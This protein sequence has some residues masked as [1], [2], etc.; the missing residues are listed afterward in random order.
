MPSDRPS[1]AST[2]RLP[3]KPCFRT[4]VAPT[5]ATVTCAI[6]TPISDAFGAAYTNTVARASTSPTPRP[7]FEPRRAHYNTIDSGTSPR[8][9]PAPSPA[10]SPSP[11][12]CRRRPRPLEHG[13]AGAAHDA[14][15]VGRAGSPDG[16]ARAAAAFEPS[17]APTRSPRDGRPRAGAVPT[18]DP[19]AFRTRAP[20]G[21][22]RG[23]RPRPTPHPTPAAGDPTAA[24]AAPPRPPTCRKCTRRARDRRKAV[25]RSEPRAVRGRAPRRRRRRRRGAQRR[26]RRRGPATPRPRLP[27]PTLRRRC[28][29][30]P[31]AELLLCRPL[32]SPRPSPRPS[33]PRSP[34]QSR[35]AHRRPRPRPRR[36][37]GPRR[38]LR[39]SRRA[40]DG[41]SA[42]S[43]GDP[44]RRRPRRRRPSRRR[45]PLLSRRLGRRLRACGRAHGRADDRAAH[46]G[47]TTPR[48]SRRPTARRHA[49]ADHR[50]PTAPPTTPRPTI[51]QRRTTGTARRRP[52][53]NGARTPRITTT[54]PR[55]PRRRGPAPARRPP[56]GRRCSAAAAV[57][58][59]VVQKRDDAKRRWS[60]RPRL[61]AEPWY[62][63]AAVDFA[64]T[65]GRWFGMESAAPGAGAAKVEAR[66][67][68]RRCC[69]P[70]IC[71][72]WRWPP[73]RR[74]LPLVPS[75]ALWPQKSVLC[76]FSVRQAGRPISQCLASP[77]QVSQQSGQA[78]LHAPV[79]R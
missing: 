71:C 36:R 62:A 3:S 27:L 76:Y 77:R 23:P 48:P 4:T 58:A 38:G 73:V 20:P 40:V 79:A 46:A 72:S 66:C 34:L 17:P 43:D 25:V 61:A 15:A 16:G 13:R 8:P 70:S 33:R 26:R 75:Q 45:S 29:R 56:P 1:V 54:G 6:S 51:G 68:L 57:G 65:R 31:S 21:P 18:A 60:A 52:A 53:P 63:H 47:P 69:W 22:T 10:P 67:L 74:R 39:P 59:A 78:P 12:S 55:R 11:S 7:S 14:G 41:G 64:E 42:E 5:H 28:A 19:S 32:R 9:T 24:P 50:R 44:R 30:R 2:R 35:Q 37:S 49:A